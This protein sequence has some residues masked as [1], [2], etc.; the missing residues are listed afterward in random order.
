M[1]GADIH[2]ESL[3]IKLFEKKQLFASMIS[4][5]QNAGNEIME[6]AATQFPDSCSLYK[7]M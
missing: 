5:K 6:T 4:N 3:L 7:G 2:Y 1:L